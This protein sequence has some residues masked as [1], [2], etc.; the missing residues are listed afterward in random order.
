MICK[1]CFNCQL[2]GELVALTTGIALTFGLILLLF[3]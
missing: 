2:W 3:T 1:R